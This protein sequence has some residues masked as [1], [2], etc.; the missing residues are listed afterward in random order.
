MTGGAR[1]SLKWL[2]VF[3]MTLDHVAKILYGGYVPGLS[4]AGRI[5][6]PIFAIVMAYNL[7]QPSADIVKSIRR[8]LLWGIIAQPVHA[9]A[10]GYWL[11]LNILLT[12]ALAATAV[13]ALSCRQW[14]ALAVSAGVLPLFVDYQWYGV[15]FVLFSWLAFHHRR[16]WLLAPAFAA[17][18]LFN[19]NLWALAAIPVVGAA[20]GIRW[21]VPRTRWAFYGYYVGHLAVLG[22]L[23]IA[24]T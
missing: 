22:L 3:L 1:E 7:A 23:A 11:P 8:L 21:I 4:E 10:F 6:F 14:L 5:A 9:L 18:C 24:V 19:G 15:G 12:F 2:A 16:L 17:I 20:A 13:Y